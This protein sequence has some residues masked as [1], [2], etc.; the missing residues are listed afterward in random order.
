MVV[1]QKAKAKKPAAAKPRHPLMLD[2]K[3]WDKQKVMEILCNRISGCSLSLFTILSQGHEGN[4]LPSVVAIMEWLQ[5]DPALANQYS[6]AKETQTEFLSEEMLQIA[7][8]GA[9][10]LMETENGPALNSEHIQRSKLRIE[11]RKWLMGKLKPKKYGDKTVTEITGK[12]GGPIESLTMTDTERKAR[13][14][15][16]VAKTTKP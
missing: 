10:D 11:T 15:E 1:K 9:N 3:S 16:L 7:D 6:R 13:L 8:D 14:A 12:D 2:G 4:T 5:A